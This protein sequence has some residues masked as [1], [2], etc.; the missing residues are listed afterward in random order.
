MILDESLKLHRELGPGLLE[1]IYE[2]LLADAL[3]AR[4]LEVARQKSIGLCHR[5]RK[6]NEAF[7]ADLIVQRAIIL[8][9][10]SIDVVLPTHKKQ[11]LTYLRLSRLQLGFLLNFGAAWMREGITRVV[12]GLP[13]S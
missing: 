12:N 1:S 13:E 3:N 11:L 9:I 2:V 7:R 8:E 10:K 5:G 6:F 4:G